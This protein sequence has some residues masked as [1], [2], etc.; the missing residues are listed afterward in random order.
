ML[1]WTRVHLTGRWLLV[2]ADTLTPTIGRF[3]AV[4]WPGAELRPLAAGH[5]TLLPRC[6]VGIA[7]MHWIK[8]QRKGYKIA[9]P[10]ESQSFTAYTI[11]KEKLYDSWELFFMK[12]WYSQPD[13]HARFARIW[14]ASLARVLR[15][16]LTK[17]F[18]KKKVCLKRLEMLWN[19]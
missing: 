9:R 16:A 17:I 12:L 6:P 5:T 19:A 7:S 3:G 14:L 8:K 10:Q 15:F 13:Q 4:T 1:T 11:S 18:E 2:L